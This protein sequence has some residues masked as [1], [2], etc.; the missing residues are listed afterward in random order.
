M[1]WNN[2]V[3][4][5]D[6][7]NK[8]ISFYLNGELKDSL[9]LATGLVYSTTDV[10]L[11]IGAETSTGSKSEF[12]NGKIQDVRIYNRA[13]SAKEVLI[14]YDMTRPDGQNMKVAENGTLYI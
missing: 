5:Y 8:K 10:K 14:N 2:V 9:T 6:S 13:L 1:L 12:H 4:S 7:Y 11:C 3:A